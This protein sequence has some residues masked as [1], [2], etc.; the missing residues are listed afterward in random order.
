MRTQLKIVAFALGLV[1]VFTVAAFIGRAV[2]P[3]GQVASPEAGH[4][5]THDETDP[6]PV[7]DVPGGLQVAQDGYRL[8]LADTRLSAGRATPL[9]FRVLGPDSLPVTEFETEHGKRLHLIVVRRD[10]TGFQ[11]LHPELAADG[12]WTAA[13]DT[14]V[15]GSYRMFADF[16]PTGR[17]DGLTLGAD[18]TVAGSYA[19]EPF[20]AESR[21]DQVDDYTVELAGSL[22]AG[23]S[24][25]LTL[26]VTKNGAPVADL[27]PY[28][29]AY[30]HLVAL[31]EGDLAYLHV[32][33][34]GTPGDGTTPA[35]PQVTFF[36]E[37]PS[38]GRYRLYLDFSHGGVVRT[39][40]FTLNTPNAAGAPS[41]GVTPPATSSPAPSASGSDTH[42]GDEHG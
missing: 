7:A 4:G 37:V 29:E 20:P 28:L 3:V 11:H 33:P 10:L 22:T 34:A 1:A 27:D 24:S 18:L 39:A 42:E 13:V 23:A 26:T 2:G 14:G 36:A 17:E 21:S 32:H 9:A 35:G 8:V 12:T 6:A 5:D 40:E 19:P 25:E 38:E 30:G 31:R 15:P 41:G 16:V